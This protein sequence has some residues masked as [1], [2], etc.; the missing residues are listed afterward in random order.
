[1]AEMGT[2]CIVGCGNIAGTHAQHLRRFAPLAFCSRQRESADACARRF[3]T[4]RVYERY[5]EVLESPDIAAVVL[6]SPP[7]FHASQVVQALEAGKP[8]LV[9]K[10]MCLTPEEVDAIARAVGRH[11]TGLLMVGENYYY[12]PVL[13]TIRRLISDGSLGRIE[14]VIVQ[15]RRL[16]SVTGWKCRLGALIE[17]GIHFVALISDVFS[18]A[19]DSV[20]AVFPG[21]AANTPERRSVT[22]LVYPGGARA[23]L[24]YSWNTPHPFFGAF[25]HSLIRAAH[26]TLT[27]ESNGLYAVLTDRSK[28]PVVFPFVTDI[29]GRGRMIRDFLACLADPSRKPYSDFAKARRDLRIVFDAYRGL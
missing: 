29:M 1:M 24:S 25:Q 17:G 4:G 11:P 12:K 10:P 22:S 5:E 18:C 21:H 6:A 28:R 19:P 16:Q 14:S 27:F 15:K 3:G 9:E 23:E 20:S 7:E 26:G 13:S 8:V 2:I